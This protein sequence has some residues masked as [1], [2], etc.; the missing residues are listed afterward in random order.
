MRKLKESATYAVPGA[1]LR[2]TEMDFAA[3][4]EPPAD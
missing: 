2:V 1:P 3:I 4:A